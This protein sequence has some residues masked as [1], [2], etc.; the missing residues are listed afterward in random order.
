MKR[1]RA[2]RNALTK[3]NP[4]SVVVQHTLFCMWYSRNT[5]L[6]VLAKVSYV[7]FS[8]IL[9]HANTAESLFKVLLFIQ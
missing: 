7:C 8:F 3:F 2:Y 5:E 1:H 4:L 6:I 9:R